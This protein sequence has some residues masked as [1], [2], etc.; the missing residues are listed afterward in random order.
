M[1]SKLDLPL[2]PF[3]TSTPTNLWFNQWLWFKGVWLFTYRASRRQPVLLIP[4]PFTYSSSLGHTAIHLLVVP[5]L[6]WGTSLDRPEP[7]PQQKANNPRA[8]TQGDNAGQC[9]PLVLR[10]LPC[11]KWRQVPDPFSPQLLCLPCLPWI[12]RSQEVGF[13]L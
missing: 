11:C 12:L 1:K 10:T 2:E 6:W 3:Y 5:V 7:S 4:H 8:G 9:Q 13:H